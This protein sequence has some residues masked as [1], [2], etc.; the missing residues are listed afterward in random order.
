MKL[1][2]KKSKASKLLSKF[3][4]WDETLDNVELLCTRTDGT[5][6]DFNRFSFP[7]KFIEKIYN[8]EITLN[9]AIND[10]TELGILINKLNNEYNPKN[11]KKVK[12][13][14]DV[15]KSARKL[16][17]TRKDIIDLFEKGTFPY[18]GNIFKNKRKRRT[19]RRRIRRIRTHFLNIL[20]M[21]QKVL[22]MILFKEY[23]NF[24]GPTDLAKKL[25]ETKDKKRNSEF[26][27]LI[28]VKW[29]NLKGEIEKMPKDKKKLKNQIKY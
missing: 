1:A 15:L 8:Y 28:K 14:N 7:L 12:E 5:K 10:Q 25:F 22:T 2:K 11:P 6:Y 26:V 3:R 17:N 19:K 13:K 20:R 4:K 23:F 29:S 27:E 18:K 9:E 16:L 24:A 21:N